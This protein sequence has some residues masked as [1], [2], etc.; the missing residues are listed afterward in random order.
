MSDQKYERF[1]EDKSEQYFKLDWSPYDDYVTKIY[2]QSIEIGN[3]DLNYIFTTFHRNINR[4]FE[5]LN[6]SIEKSYFTAAESRDLLFWCNEIKE[7][8]SMLENSKWSFRII[9][10]YHDYLYNQ[11]GFLCQS[12]GSTIPSNFTKIK[13]VKYEPIFHLATSVKLDRKNSV[14]ANSTL[15]GTGSYANVYKFKDTQYDKWF[16]QKKAFKTL[17][18]K[19]LTRFE[20]EFST[21]K[22]IYS[23]YVLEVYKYNHDDNSYVMEYADTTIHDFIR[24]HN[25]TLTMNERLSLINQVIKAFMYLE[26]KSILHRDISPTNILIKKYDHVNVVKV[27][28]FGLVKL[29]ESTLTS[30]H[31]EIKGCF[32]D[33]KLKLLGFENYNRKHET[34][35][36]TRLIYYIYSGR[37]NLEKLIETDPFYEYVNQGISDKLPERYESVNEMNNK[38]RTLISNLK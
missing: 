7:C 30:L 14:Y 31:S 6:Q 19:E 23:P 1:I 15:I 20:K 24:K 38:F 22:E 9:P 8:K 12:N 27:S 21:M 17:N 33:P 37:T 3:Y 2:R 35:A 32:N 34:Y 10:S 29:D 5:S 16:A 11:L 13:I 26:S 28:D 4:L 18:K 36:L 25:S